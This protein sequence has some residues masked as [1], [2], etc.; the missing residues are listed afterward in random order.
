MTVLRALPLLLS[1]LAPVVLAGELSELIARAEQNDP[2]YKA[3]LAAADAVRSERGVARAGLLPE[4]SFQ[5]RYAG[6][7]QDIDVARG[8]FGLDGRQR[9]DSEF[10][11]AN[12][13]QPILHWDRWLTL[14]KSDERVAQVEADVAAYYAELVLRIAERYFQVVGA[15]GDL[16][17]STAELKALEAQLEQ[18]RAR[19]E[20]GSATEAE[21][22]EAQADVDRAAADLIR[23]QA[24]IDIGQDALAELVGGSVDVRAKIAEDIVLA[25]PAPADLNHWRALAAERHPRVLAARALV[26][27][28]DYDRRIAR[29]GHLPTMDLVGR[30]G[31]DSQGGRFGNTDITARSIGVELEVPIFAGGAVYYSRQAATHRILEAAERAEVE[32]RGAER[33]VSEAYRRIDMSIAQAKA[34]ERAL[35]SSVAALEAVRTQYDAGFRTIADVMDA[36]KNVFD[37]RRELAE[38]RIRYVVDTLKLKYAS[39]ELALDDLAA[40]EGLLEPDLAGTDT[41]SKRL[42]AALIKPPEALRETAATQDTAATQHTAAAP[43]T[44]GTQVAP[45]TA[46]APTFDA[47]G[48]NV[49]PP[50]RTDA[51][52]AR[53]ADLEERRTPPTGNWQVNAASFRHRPTAAAMAAT[54]ADAG[55]DVDILEADVDGTPWYRV[56]IT[57]FTS[58]LDA[59]AAAGVIGTLI[60]RDQLWITNR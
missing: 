38:A 56:R 7:T 45:P 9:F 27:V 1:A 19:F 22:I 51:P 29:A 35:G 8:A 55:Y 42:L 20:L 25:G 58:R 33:A 24:A 17:T 57:G 60:D 3:A 11:E 54:L 14:K 34:S 26:D 6:N 40:A 30:Y 50:A 44:A 39:G 2:G 52:P 36:Q 43:D 12:A 31:L 18:V 46:P 28:A 10:Y 16:V 15:R 41:A 5:A 23:A 59:D 21:L 37:A 4:V 13:R 47:T 32:R 53:A 48:P 49:Q